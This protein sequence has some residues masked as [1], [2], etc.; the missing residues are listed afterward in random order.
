MSTSSLSSI[1]RAESTLVSEI[2]N[3]DGERKA[4]VYDNYSKLIRATETIAQLQK[5]MDDREGGGLQVVETLVPSVR[6][7]AETAGDIQTSRQGSSGQRARERS[8][9]QWVLDAPQRL[10]AMA[11]DGQ[12]QLAKEEWQDV[13]EL[14]DSWKAVK[15]TD[16][17]RSS[18]EAALRQ[19]VTE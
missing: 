2:K 7:V 12:H 4:L 3:L 1:L 19:T 5:G 16:T 17:V 9:V 10:A 14:L 8:T 13:R 6:K 15:G 18:C 11:Q